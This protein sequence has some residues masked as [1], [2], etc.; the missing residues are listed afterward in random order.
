MGGHV[1]RQVNAGSPG[2]DGSLTLPATR[3]L[4][5]DDQRSSTSTSTTGEQDRGLDKVPGVFPFIRGVI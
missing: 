5:G 2:S 4:T 1:I 3:F